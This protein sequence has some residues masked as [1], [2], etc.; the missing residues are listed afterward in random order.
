MARAESSAVPMVAGF[1]RFARHQEIEMAAGGRLLIAELSCTACHNAA[2]EDLQP[3]RGPKLEGVGDRVQ[4]DW[5]ERF[6]TSPQTAKP[7]TT[8][9]DVLV[10][11]PVTEKPK[12]VA[13]LAAFLATEHQPYPVLPANGGKALP[14]EFWNLGNA[15]HGQQLYHTVGCVACHEPDQDQETVSTEPSAIDRLLEELD[16]EEL[17]EMG[18]D[19]AARAVPSVPHGDLGAK[20]TH[21]SL[22]FFLL[23][24]EK[25][26]PSGR[27][28]SFKLE[29]VE[30]SDI[31]AYLLRE[32][33]KNVAVNPFRDDPALVEE[34]KRLF[35]RFGCVN[36]HT[37]TG[38]Q[39]SLP[40]KPL[41]E[42][43]T[44]NKIRCWGSP[45][46]GLPQFALD[47]PQATAVVAAIN[48][49]E[50][51][52][53]LPA[54][55]AISSLMLRLNCYAYH[56]RDGRGGVDRKR[57]AYF[58]TVRHIDIG[59][60]GR[61]PPPLDGVGRKLKIDWLKKVFAGSG[62]VRPHLLARMPKYPSRMVAQLPSWFAQ[63]DAVVTRTEK[64]VFGEYKP[65][66]SAGRVLLNTGCVQCHPIR[67]E[68]LP[69]VVGVDLANV[70]ARIRPDWFHEFLLDPSKFKPRTRMPTFFPEGRGQD[71]NVLGGDANL[72]VAAL[73]AYLRDIKKQPLPQ[74]IEQ[75]RSQEFELVPT[76]RPILL[77]TFMP[78]AGTHA[79]AVGFPQQVHY[80]FDA[81]QMR[82]A[83]A[84]RGK[85]LDAKGTWFERMAPPAL[86][87][88]D[89]LVEL[90][91]GVP[92]ALLENQKQAWP[93][94]SAETVGYKFLGY[95]LDPAGIP[96]LLYRYRDFDIQ[97]RIV[98]GEQQSL[99]RLLSIKAQSSAASKTTLWF[100]ANQGKQLKHQL[101]SST[102]N[103]S[104]LT[105]LISEPAG[106]AGVVRRIGK[107]VEWIVPVDVYREATIQ[108]EYQW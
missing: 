82:L 1:D 38:V 108:V 41:G 60:E 11:L 15:T 80:A 91:A 31:A 69:G 79:I 27:M 50:R 105:V 6:L 86:P 85:F 4:R 22:T 28:P 61:I 93:V 75:A 44:G 8:M 46:Q 40:A 18:L 48:E 45:S 16:P 96:T 66:A 107:T 83:Q 35:V 78:V 97:D 53:S 36:C 51:K 106:K 88:G 99:S 29:P 104:G 92:L 64:E 34:G 84:W 76:K 59:D 95:R 58:E 57:K 12:I 102:T 90:P 54:Q 25:V 94:A 7:G 47:Q 32:Q 37:A 26:R 9:P 39:G 87:L 71:K 100:R 68:R 30:A 2:D 10:G 73:W 33:K 13:A 81:E 77:R 98:P 103:E 21:K 23:D 55:Q 19:A 74:K 62:E 56:Q 17:A 70:T 24:P 65:L 20:Y 89:A 52:E 43:Q 49:L 3:K 72:Q 101:E 5:I 14:D 63:A 67:G 42:L